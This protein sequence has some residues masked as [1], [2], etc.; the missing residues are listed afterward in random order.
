MSFDIYDGNGNYF[1]SSPM[2]IG[3]NTFPITSPAGTTFQWRYLWFLPGST[4]VIYAY[5][6]CCNE[7]SGKPNRKLCGV[8]RITQGEISPAA[9]VSS[10]VVLTN[11][12]FAYYDPSVS[13]WFLKIQFVDSVPTCENLTVHYDEVYVK[14]GSPDSATVTVNVGSLPIISGT[15]TIQIEVHPNNTDYGNYL[16]SGYIVDCCSTA[17]HP[18]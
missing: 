7:P 14:T 10:I 9:C 12:P 1:S 11:R 16:Y 15:K 13:K 5:A 4:S 8:Y 18:F 2:I 3:G 6:D 17:H